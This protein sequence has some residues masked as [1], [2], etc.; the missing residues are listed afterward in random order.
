MGN[1]NRDRG[2][3]DRGS[4]GRGGDRRG[5]GGDSRPEMHR[6]TCAECGAS[7]E[8]PFKPTGGKPV[9][10]SNCFSNKEGSAPRRSNDRERSRSMFGSDRGERR[11]FEAVCDGCGKDCEV[12]FKPSEDKPV[13]C[14]ECFG[15]NNDLRRSEP[16]RNESRGNSSDNS[17]TKQIEALNSKLD[18]V[19]QLLTPKDK[20]E[21]VIKLAPQGTKLAPKEI[22]KEKTVKVVKKE[23][24]KS[25]KKPVVKKAKVLKK[26]GK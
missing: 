2:S 15:K 26:K 23:V 21:E 14:D 5:R 22:K 9:Y 18:K 1:F 16:K 6:A 20:K 12:P 10:C 11:M 13:Y 4:F 25:S 19:I 3:R 24:K 17:L 7:C 8:V